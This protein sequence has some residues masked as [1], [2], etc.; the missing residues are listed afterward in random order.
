MK[1]QTIGLLV[2]QFLCF[3]S[4]GQDFPHKELVAVGVNKPPVLDG[5]LSDSCWQKAPI[6]KDFVTQYPTPGLPMPQASEVK[7]IYSQEA[8]YIGFYCKDSAPDSILKQLTGRDT[9]GNSDWCSIIINCY[10]DGINGLMFAVSATGEQWDGKML[11]NSEPDVSWN[12]VWDC[13]T[14]VVADGWCAEFKIPYAAIRFPDVMEQNWDINFAR[15][16]R[17]YRSVGTWNP[18][19][20]N[21]PGDL[22]QMGILKGI[23]NIHP[24]KRIFFYPYAS[25]YYNFGSGSNNFSYNLG[26][27][28]KLGLGDAFTLDGTLIPDFGQTISDQKI[29]NL[30]PFEIQFQDNRQ[31]FM[32]GT[33]LFNKT[34][35]F[36]SRRIG[37][38]P[39]GYFDVFEQLDSN[40]TLSSNPGQAQ[41]LNSIKVSGRTKSN[42][43]L[44]I[45]NSVTAHTFAEIV[46]SDGGKRSLQT[47][48]LTN[49]NVLVIDQNLKNNSYFNLTNTNVT[50]AG[51]TYDA[52]V[53]SYIMELKDKRNLFSVSSSGAFSHLAG[54]RPFKSNGF[55]QDGFTQSTSIN[56]IKGRYT[57]SVGYY[58]ESD[59]YDPNDLGFL[60]ANNSFN[61][62]ASISYDL[63]KN[64]GPFNKIR[65]SSSIM[66]SMLYNPMVFTR[67]E[68]DGSLL[69]NTQKFTTFNLSVHSEPVRGMDYFE[70]RVWG[71]KYHDFRHTEIG[72]WI[73]TD[74]RKRLA[75]DAGG[76]YG[77]YENIAREIINARFSPRFRLNDHWMFIYVYSL[78]QHFNDIGFSTFDGEIP[79]FG[80]RDVISHTSVLTV[81]CAVNPL[82]S[83]NCR[84]RH[85]WGF[86]NYKALYN[87]DASGELVNT[88]FVP[89]ESVNRNFNTFT[90]DCF[91]KWNFTPGSYCIVGYKWDQ[92]QEDKVIPSSLWQDME[93]TWSDIPIAGN[94]SIRLIY[95]LDYRLLTK[96]KGEAIGKFM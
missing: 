80:K 1:K 25:G 6:A 29:L 47:Q 17:R 59:R 71:L 20:P 60:Q 21:G 63:Y 22:V 14:R 90:I 92:T 70:P 27:D 8:L 68:I 58:M 85:Y 23:Q 61:Q 95:F 56:K 7:V 46:N 78:Q 84:F 67:L 49:Y 66:R 54:N 11:G 77:K 74:Y 82:L 24:P 2:L 86:S 38:M 50:R 36:Y 62:F 73:S 96:N 65:A 69:L 26:L 79:V 39:I 33:E 16:I 45:M 40:E 91:L 53:T 12:A 3:G 35:I 57:G 48:P 93:N 87:L 13:K 41:I 51:E 10:Q 43:G 19:N 55:I 42:T 15:E 31:F 75:A 5:F 89:T 34:G 72:G 83:I 81:N 32:E 18:V 37:G 94:T 28:L 64:V 4:W 44:G 30:T 88:D 9:E 52:N 76:R